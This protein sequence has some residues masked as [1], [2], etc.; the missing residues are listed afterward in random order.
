ML[1]PGEGC[2]VLGHIDEPLHGGLYI[3]VIGC[4]LPGHI[5]EPRGSLQILVPGEGCVV[6]G[7]IDEPLHS[8]LL[9]LRVHHS[10]AEPTV[11]TVK[12]SINKVAGLF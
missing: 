12:C 3:Y 9:T 6:P 2:V 4:V 8:G 7:H 5:D 10:Q 11:R 1:V